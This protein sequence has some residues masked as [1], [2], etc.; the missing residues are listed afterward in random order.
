[1][2][3]RRAGAAPGSRR[4]A[5][6]PRATYRLQFNAGFTLHDATALVP[7]LAELGV[8]HVY[9]SPLCRARPGSTHG[10]DIVD[11]STFNPE[12]GDAGDFDALV[13][14]LRAHGMG[15][16]LDI[17]P[18]HVGVMGSGNA[19]WMDVLEN[20]QSSRYATFF[21][22]DWR[23]PNPALAGRLLVPVL[24]DTYG[25]VLERG[26]LEL[27]FEPEAGALAVWYH[28]HRFPLDPRS[29]PLVLER[30]IAALPGGADADDARAELR[31]LCEALAGLPAHDDAEPAQV[32]RRETGRTAAQRRLAAAARAPVA[33][34]AIAA[35]VAGFAGR[36]GDASSYD[37]LHELLERQAF[38]LAYWRVAADD[39]NYRRF[40]DVNDLAALCVE[41]D[42]VFE[43]TSRFAIDLVLAGKVDGLRVD[44]P[45]GLRDPAL[46][47][48]RLQQATTGAADFDAETALAAA[49]RRRARELPL[50]LLAEKITAPFEKLPT[51]WLVHGTTGYRFANVVNGLFV[52]PRARATMDRTY[53]TFIGDYVDWPEVAYESKLMVMRTALA[54]ELN[55]LANQLARIAATDRHTRDFTLNSLRGALAEVIA[56]FPVYRTY[57]AESVSRDDRRYIDWAV[58]RARRRGSA[59]DLPTYEFV[60]DALCGHTRE[61]SGASVVSVREFAMRC[62]QV[63]APIAAKGVEDTALYR[64]TRLAALN[65]VGGDP[66]SFG[67]SVRQFHRDCRQRAATWPYEMLT[68]STHDTKRSEDVRARLDV[69]TE[70]PLRWRRWLQRWSRMNRVRRR[71]VDDLPVPGPH[72][73]YLLYQTLLGTWPLEPLDDAAYA[74]YLERITTYMVKAMREAKRRTSWMNVNREYETALQAFVHASLERSA[75]GPFVQELD[76]A[77]REVARFGFLN[78]LAATLCKLTAPGVPDLYQ[79]T[80][81][82]DFSLVDPDNRRP[83]DFALRRGALAGL[84]E[85]ASSP[86]TARAAAVR[87]LLDSAEDGRAKLYVTWRAL[88]YRRL[89][90]RLFRD[91]SYQPLA[92]HGMHAAHLCAYA[93]RLGTEWCIVIVPR[94][95]ARLLD[96]GDGLPLGAGV[97][98][99]TSI[100]LPRHVAADR[101]LSFLDGGAP[102]CFS[103]LA[104]ARLRA[105]D[106]LAHLPLAMLVPARDP[107][108]PRS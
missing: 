88:E 4:T 103:G 52:D 79:G 107:Y 34:R 41:K 19:W 40:F 87:R 68:T 108:A 7:Y 50:Y 18:N 44:H 49:P 26:E 43:A 63:T 55:V 72:A 13:T 22:I 78:G 11:H 100:E 106:A 6:V 29:Y 57:V 98:G 99:D 94:L 32:E 36:P 95:C 66:D 80:E 27:R 9:C 12:I 62:Q 37:A 51:G 5:V 104:G 102:A 71:V 15:I 56:W 64:F 73:E 77:A 2:V 30:A 70:L 65:E 42:A 76:R 10:Y 23:P 31:V 17:V 59:V 85:L 86:A 93:R 91:G 101:L 24:G 38:R 46:Y 1:M 39:I 61:G 84:R 67:T 90:A 105:A 60:H 14:A 8:S 48:R 33:D 82:W 35:A 96:G 74:A 54:A 53:R 16:V 92:T 3:P 75:G 21:D 20:G 83:V 81:L 28:E 69:L 89:H 97:W 47:F 25:S 58:A 45:D